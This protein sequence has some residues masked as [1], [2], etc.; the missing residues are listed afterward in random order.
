MFKPFCR[1]Q[2]PSLCVSLPWQAHFY[3]NSTLEFQDV[4]HVTL[5]KSTLMFHKNNWW[6]W[7]KP[8]FQ[9]PS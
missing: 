3:E 7:F 4:D 5:D 9:Q 1:L 6:V 2:N 8:G